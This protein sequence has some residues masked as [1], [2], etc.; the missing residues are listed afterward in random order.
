LTSCPAPSEGFDDRQYCQ[1]AQDLLALRINKQRLLEGQG[2]LLDIDTLL[3][4]GGVGTT[5]RT[6]LSVISIRFLGGLTEIETEAEP[7]TVPWHR[8]GDAG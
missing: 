4:R 1:L 8:A 7:R 2:E 5:G 6:L 3:G